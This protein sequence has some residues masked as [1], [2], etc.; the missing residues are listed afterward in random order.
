MSTSLIAFLIFAGIFLLILLG[1]LFLILYSPRR[2]GV[3][4]V[5]RLRYD[6]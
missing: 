1:C 6:R 2:C 3:R 4:P 5:L